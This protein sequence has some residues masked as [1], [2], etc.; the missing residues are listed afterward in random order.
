[1]GC[2]RCTSPQ[3]RLQFGRTF[4]RIAE[5]DGYV[6]FLYSVSSREVRVI[7]TRRLLSDDRPAA[8]VSVRRDA[9][10]AENTAMLSLSSLSPPPTPAIPHTVGSHLPSLLS[11]PTTLLG[12]SL[13]GTAAPALSPPPSLLRRNSSSAAEMLLAPLVAPAVRASG[14]L[15]DL[16]SGVPGIKYAVRMD[17][18][19][20]APLPFL[21]LTDSRSLL[22]S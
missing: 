17:D 8:D 2:R 16:P 18:Q 22:T 13:G 10:W 9:S 15:L 21:A 7:D 12:R 20:V 19:K 14:R 4:S 3:R 5:S 6:L 11:Q 1:M